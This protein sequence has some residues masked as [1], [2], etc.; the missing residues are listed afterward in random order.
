MGVRAEVQA[1][2]R[3]P[4]PQAHGHPDRGRRREREHR[5][6]PGPVGAEGP[7]QGGLA[8]PEQGQQPGHHEGPEH[9]ELLL[10]GQR[11]QV[12]EQR[13]GGGREVVGAAEDH[14]PVA[15]VG[16][17]AE[18]LPAQARREL[19]D[20]EPRQRRAADQRHHHG[21]HQ[22]PHAAHPEG[23]EAQPPAAVDPA[24]Q[25][26]GDQEAGEYEEHVHA[27]EPARQQGRP[28]VE[29]EDR[30]HGHAAQPVQ[31]GDAAGAGA[32][33][34]AGAVGVDEGAGARTAS[35]IRA[36]LGG[37]DGGG[38]GQ[39][40]HTSDCR[41]HVAAHHVAPG[42]DVSKCPARADPAASGGPPPPPARVR[43]PRRRRLRTARSPSRPRPR[44]CGRRRARRA[45]RAWS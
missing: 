44:P 34:D 45:G 10:D 12:L 15:R 7:A 5:E 41:P 13:R 11:P 27:H 31:G 1:R 16:Q 14:H 19:R 24:D 4:A 43:R 6:H 2:V 9:V 36:L 33:A 20:G 29:H 28:G 40:G 38:R 35:S 18:P 22:A 25:A 37:P 3:R 32:H 26:R 21:R 42:R 23:S 8:R 30:E 39:A 17:R